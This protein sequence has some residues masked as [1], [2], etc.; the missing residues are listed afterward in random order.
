MS[1]ELATRQTDELRA[2]A[3]EVVQNAGDR[4]EA[5]LP[6]HYPAAK[7][8]QVMTVLAAR[9]PKILEC[10]RES[11]VTS[12][13]QAATLDLD[14]TPAAAEGYLIP[15]WNDK[16]KCQECQFQPG[17]KGLEKLAV[18][19]G[20]VL[21]IQ[22]DED[23]EGDRFRVWKTDGV[24]HLEHEPNFGR[25]GRVRHYYAAAKMADGSVLVEVMTADDVEAIHQRSDGY[26]TAKAKGWKEAGPWVTDYDAMGRKTVIRKL[27]KSLP[28]VA[29]GGGHSPAFAA[30]HSAIEADSR[31]YE[32]IDA[33]PEHHAV[34][35]NN[36]TGHGRTGAYAPPAA[37][38]AF[39]AWLTSF[40]AERNAAWLDYWQVIAEREEDWQGFKPAADLFPSCDEF[41]L[42]VIDWAA[43]HPD[44]RLS[45]P[46]EPK[47]HQIWQFAAVPWLKNET[48]AKKLVARIAKAGWDREQKAIAAAHEAEQAGGQASAEDESQAPPEDAGDGDGDID[49]P[50]PGSEG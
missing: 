9:S 40:L 30:L 27:C 3:L 46:A 50:E 8:S 18:R 10:Y 4:L 34:N 12:L 31:Q 20:T 49:Y 11:I 47:P 43:R 21:W 41:A 33:P 14:L 23:R 32:A 45:A 17:Y 26:K 13:I 36:H 1:T 28:R 35:H 25:R 19:T 39:R 5:A 16:L 38:E 37:V 42:W 48:E 15:R 7:L 24:T 29:P 2:R 44:F 22:P 6:S